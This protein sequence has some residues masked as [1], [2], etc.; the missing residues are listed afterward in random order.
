MTENYT[1]ILP[2][3]ESRG[4]EFNG[5]D[6]YRFIFPDNESSGERSTDFSRPNAIYLYAPSEEQG[7]RKLRRRIMLHD[8]WERDYMEFVE[9]NPMTLCSGLS[10]RGRA[11]RVE[12]AQR[13]NALIFDLDGVGQKEI[14]TLF[15]RFDRPPEKLR[16]LPRPTF[17]V[18]SGNGIHLYYVFREPIDLFP[19]IKV[20]LKALKY[21]LTFRIWEYKST[22]QQRAIQYQSIN[23]GF[24][25]VG[26]VN[27]KYDTE[28]RAFQT[29]ERVTLD[30]LNQYVKPSERVDINRPFQPSKMTREAAKIA[31]PEWYQRVIVEG[32][33]GKKKWDIAAKVNGEDPYALYHWWIRQAGA[34]RGGHRYYFLMCMAI[35]ASKCDVPKKKLCEDMADVFKELQGVEHENALT[36]TDVDSALEAYSKEYYNFTIA[37][38]EKL[39]DIRIERNKRNGRPRALHLRLARAN[40][41]ILCEARGEADWRRGNGRPIGSGTAQLRVMEYRREH[42]AASVSEVARALGIS[43]PTVYKWWDSI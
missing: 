1:Q 5:F 7:T 29:G 16:T 35:Y 25:M 4:T 19:N 39:T 17:I 43:R 32:R 9:Q 33:K 10:Y 40:R 26:S 36:K 20:Q 6:F 28:M 27:A 34:V 38:I 11:N 22:S 41:D 24:R 23:Q 30:Y 15:I 12:N 31:Y 14:E 37:D 2:V 3:L 13:M 18:A 21:A 8:T 42:P